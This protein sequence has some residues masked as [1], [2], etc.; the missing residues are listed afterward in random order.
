[1]GEY[2]I[3][4]ADSDCPSRILGSKMTGIGAEWE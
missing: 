1:M 3:K 4:G 2:Q